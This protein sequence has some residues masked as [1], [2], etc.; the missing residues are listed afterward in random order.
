MLNPGM[1][2]VDAGELGHR[3]RIELSR[4][5]LAADRST[6][7]PPE[8][9]LEYRRFDQQ[10]SATLLRLT[11]ALVPALY[12]LLF[13]VDAL[14]AR[15]LQTPLAVILCF[16]IGAPSA[17]ALCLLVYLPKRRALAVQLAPWCNLV[18]GL[19]IVALCVAA[20]RSHQPFHYELLTL[21]F[22]YTFFLGG[23]RPSA[24]AAV[25][26]III[27]SYAVAETWAGQDLATLAWQLCILIALAALGTLGSF[28][29]DRSQRQFW[30]QQVLTTELSIFDGLTGLYNHR[31]LKAQGDV[32][33]RHA[34]RELRPVALMLIDVDH[35]KAYEDLQGNAAGDE[36]LRRLAARIEATG[37][38][39]LDIAARY[40]GEEFAVLMYD[41][42]EPQAQR[43]A[44]QLCD[45][46]TA[47]AI[48]HPGSATGVVSVSVGVSAGIPL[49]GAEL[50]TYARMAGS[51]LQLAKAN[52]RNRTEC[53]SLI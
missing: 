7:F 22:A 3:V 5:L 52:G 16:G 47:L 41:C 37:R 4:R 18:N 50:E 1:A 15:R 11:L 46:V 42:V 17:L 12:G 8:L 2:P 38:R 34:A 9:E 10:R 21:V 13:V 40:G 33:L 48:A 49:A 29:L 45:E 30:L 19:L 39:P 25:A 26:A 23:L 24:A 44:Q 43:R 32:V 51:A 6:P 31:Y 35:F 36:C 14:F 53:S 20:S 27:G 28:M